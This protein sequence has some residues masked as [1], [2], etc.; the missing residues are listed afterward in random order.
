M[1]MHSDITLLAEGGDLV[2]Q[3]CE[4]L[5]E[6]E[7]MLKKPQPPEAHARIVRLQTAVSSAIDII[8]ETA[9][10]TAD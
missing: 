7:T 1:N 9:N 4:K 10:E 3:F 6:F 5:A 8:N 2:E